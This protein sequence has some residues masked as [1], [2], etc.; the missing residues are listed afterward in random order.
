MIH[1]YKLTIPGDSI[2][3]R[4]PEFGYFAVGQ[5]FLCIIGYTGKS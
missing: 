3:K 2:E 5:P 4:I 1:V